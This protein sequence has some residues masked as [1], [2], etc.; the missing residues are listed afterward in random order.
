MPVV[1]AR[2]FARIAARRGFTL[3]ELVA[4]ISIV[5]ILA[6]LA[7]PRYI[8]LQSDARNAKAQ[9]IYGTI[10]AASA[11]AKIRCDLDISQGV[12]G[13]C[14]PAAG[15][16]LMDGVNIAMVNRYPA[17]TAA[18]IDAAANILASDGMVIAGTNPRT[19]QMVGAPAPA[20]C[21][22]SYTEAVAGAAPVTAIDVTNC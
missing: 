1:T 21:Q 8:N 17:G 4:V 18:G 2:N 13:Q 10:R 16:V 15:Q 20:N 5:A 14:T 3:V 12:A 7:M 19:Y 11:L 9:A 22:I 6:A